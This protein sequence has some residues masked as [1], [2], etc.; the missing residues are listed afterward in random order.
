MRVSASFVCVLVLTMAG[1]VRAEPLNPKQVSADAKW[2]AHLDADAMRSSVVV[3]AGYKAQGEKVNAFIEGVPDLHA[4]SV[5]LNQAK[6]LKGITC[7]G[8]QLKP[9][10]VAIVNANLA[11]PALRTL[12]DAIRK[13]PDYATNSHGS[14]DLH[15]WTHGKG[16]AHEH[17]VTAVYVKPNV[18]IFG[19]SAGE[20]ENA[21]DVL[22][23]TK[24]NIVG[25]SALA[26]PVPAGA[27]VMARVA[28]LTSV[29]RLHIDMPILKQADVL[30]LMLG[31]DNNEAFIIGELFAK[32][33]KTAGQLKEA[34]DKAF[35]AGSQAIE[36]AD[37]AAMID[38]VQVNAKDKVVTLDLRGPADA[39][40]KYLEK[41]AQRV[42]QEAKK[43]MAAPE[44]QATK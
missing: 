20:V 13:L 6:A 42:A 27:L 2:L 44:S 30:G 41:L 10:G 40:Y 29:D 39:S 36:D 25:K 14:H 3:D 33:A 32:N 5:A 4:V 16:A 21:L 22:D 23:G 9:G 38:A 19:V 7:Y 24:P 11:T 18:L 17:A 15:T 26:A 12:L 35:T 28:G 31:E 37:L 34:I 8:T 43:R 1:L